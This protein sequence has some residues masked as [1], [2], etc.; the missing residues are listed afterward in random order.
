MIFSPYVHHPATV[1]TTQ[2][3]QSTFQLLVARHLKWSLNKRP[4]MPGSKG[5]PGNSA[6]VS[7]IPLVIRMVI[8]MNPGTGVSMT[9]KLEVQRTR[10]GR[11]AVE[12]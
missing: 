11:D 5:E 1:S 10:R 6:T 7:H 4:R 2:V 3:A 8:N 9:P 12:R